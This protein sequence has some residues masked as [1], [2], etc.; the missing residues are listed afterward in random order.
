M[1]DETQQQ[2]QSDDETKQGEPQADQAEPQAD[3]AGPQAHQVESQADLAE[4]QAD[5]PESQADQPESQA[6]QAEPQADLSESQADLA[7]SQ[8]DQAEV[9]AEDVEEEEAKLPPIVATAEDSG[10]LKKKVT[11]T[12]P[13]VRID[14]KFQEM[15]GKLSETAQVPGFRIGRAPRRLLEKR[16]GKEVSEDVRNAL[17]GESLVSA[18][19]KAGLE[20]TIG[21]PELKLDEI[22]LPDA[23]DLSFSFE[24]EVPPEFDL[25]Q[26]QG[27]KVT[28][29]KL[30][31]TDEHIQ[32][33]LEQ[34]RQARAHF[35]V[36]EGPAA[37]GDV[38][39]G[40]AKI[41][42]EGL[43][44]V[45]RPGLTLRVAP[46]QVEGLPLVDLGKALCG[47]RAG[48]SA[49][50]TIKVPEAHPNEAWRGKNATVDIAVSQVRRR[51]LPELNEEFATSSGFDSL[52]ELRKYLT[53][54]LEHRLE[55]EVKQSMRDQVCRYLLDNTKF[56]VPAGVATRHAVGVL[57]RRYVDLLHRGAPRE[58]IDENLAQLQAAAAEQSLIDLKLMFIMDKVAEAEEIEVDDA[59]VNA[60]IADMAAANKRRPERLR[61][62]LESDGSMEQVRLSLRE[63]KTLDRLLEQA[64]V[65]EQAEE[66]PKPSEGEGQAEAGAAGA[67]APEP[68]SEG[69]AETSAAS[70]AAPE[71]AESAQEAEAPG[72]PTERSTKNGEPPEQST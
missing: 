43:E 29:P 37:E 2:P 33:Y 59:E 66:A 20:K 7:E 60:R 47:K 45:D 22:K 27:I 40:G 49:S 14:A 17:I 25:P 11:V 52:A 55:E 71:A 13:R 24:V 42:V 62:E 1:P 72:K 4:P 46:G 58:K 6:G 9:E 44:P 23:G 30:A 41:T 35:E 65:T 39:V 50:L 54:R 56:D 61:Q 38:V 32:E 34:L 51:H 19:E 18:L 8:A 31:V 70:G 68:E 16:F 57:R 15:F 10:L 67:E 36:A 48:E 26:I 53:Q 12:V 5:Q 69:E 28:R 64:E 21:E 63:E 3:Q